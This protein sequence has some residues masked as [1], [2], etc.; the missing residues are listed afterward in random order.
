MKIVIIGGGKLGMA[1]AA[2]LIKEG[3]GVTVIDRN[4]NV[5]NRGSDML[6]A[7]FLLGSGVNLRTLKEADVSH[8]DL[9]IAATA[10]DEVNMLACLT[11]KR[12]GIKKAIARIRD[13]EYFN[14]LEFLQKELS[15][16]AVINPERTT[17]REISRMLRFP[18]A[19]TVE[20]F[21]HGRVEMVGFEA[22][23]EDPFVGLT[24]N[25]IYEV[26]PTLPKV[27]FA[28]VER[29]GEAVIPRGDFEIHL[30]DV[31]HVVAD[32]RTMTQFFTFI[33]RY[34]SKVRHVMMIGGGRI[35]YYLGGVL[36]VMRTKVS[37]IEQNENRA[38]WLANSLP[39]V[40][41]IVGDGT[42]QE[43]LESE[44]LMDMDAFV[45]LTDRDEDNLMAGF[46]ALHRGVRHI[47]VKSSRDTYSNMIHDMGLDC[48]ISPMIVAC[49]TILKTVR[50]WDSCS[51]TTME[52]MYRLVGGQV[53][54]MEFVVDD[55]V[56]FL[57]IPLKS[58]KIDRDCLVAILVR[59][60]T[61]KIPFGD[62]TIE[63]NDHIVII[64]R[65]L[66][67]TELNE[68]ISK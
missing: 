21:S 24:V 55:Q 58:L 5:V 27:L 44:H 65:K 18:F 7:L 13:P 66:G 52:K 26:N 1:L 31:V 8:N 11:C 56:E 59:G 68:A 33:N 51:S 2:G 25:R 40:N 60:D 42:D 46:Y 16:D 32:S 12:M 29:D 3:H 14:N 30:G 43:L 57:H 64:T 4:E 20:T 50:A 35:A 34:T 10:N 45:T 37:I 19:E 38:R 15:I 62:D 67:L 39:N 22:L 17:A 36:D 61:V 49:N 48:L 54:A 9:V 47:I 53:E 63:P 28:V 41:I 6:D 23:E